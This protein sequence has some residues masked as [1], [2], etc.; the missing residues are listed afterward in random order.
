LIE[1]KLETRT[2]AIPRKATLENPGG[3]VEFQ[4]DEDTFAVTPEM[5]EVFDWDGCF[6]VRNFLSEEEL[7]KLW[8]ALLM[9]ESVTK[10]AWDLDD[11]DGRASRLVIWS[12]PG[13]DVTGILARS[14][15]VAGSCEKLMGGEVYHYH[16]KVMMKEARTGGK[17]LWHQDY[18]YWYKNGCLRPDMMT[19]FIAMDPC[20]RENGGLQVLKGTHRCGRIDHN[21]VHGQTGADLERVD[22]LSKHF[23]HVY[24]DLNPGD[25]LFFHCNLLHMS[26]NNPSDQRRYAFLCCYNRADNDPVYKHHHPNYTKLDKVPN[27]AIMEC[28]NFTDLSGKEFM[29][30]TKDKTVRATLVEEKT[31]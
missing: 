1:E 20:T 22:Q 25:A 29:D 31:N 28:T 30:P 10:R 16:T 8:K 15:K 2:M 6:V 12:H 19:V 24:A 14:E 17:H 7:Q 27:S 5:Q 26:A 3:V 13:S 11:G 23:E 21:L 9:N 4:Y 18:G